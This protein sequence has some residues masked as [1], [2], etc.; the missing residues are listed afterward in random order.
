MNLQFFVSILSPLAPFFE[1][2]TVNELRINPNGTIYIEQQGITSQVTDLSLS[3][4]LLEFAVS[5]LSG[6]A[7]QPLNEQYP[8]LDVRL[9][10][11][12]RIAVLAPP[13]VPQG[14]AVTLRRFPRAYTLPELVTVGTLSQAQ[15]DALA[16][17]ILRHKNLI[18]SG[19]T[20]AGK[21][22]LMRTL[23]NLI[24]HP[25][26]RLVLIEQPAELNLAFAHVRD[27]VAMEVRDGT[28]NAPAFTATDALK[29]AL[30]HSPDRI[31]FGELRGGEAADFLDALNTGHAGSLTTLHAN[32]AEDALGRLITL[33][34]R[35]DSKASRAVI[36]DTI[37]RAIQVVVH[38]DKHADRRVV[39]EIITI[40][41][42]D[43]AGTR[44]LTAPLIPDKGGL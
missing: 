10:D 23:L 21:T 33:V 12:S 38:M 14:H 19:G 17:L 6:E 28:P 27:I 42:I 39:S 32:S 3:R 8:K 9:E 43:P 29:A 7:N 36:L 35:G 13:L 41:G 37:S 30:R 2:E 40:T 44:I 25:G 26:E 1:D 18:V 11:G 4:Q 20:G 22:T 5:A 16:H 15:A 24:P 31:I 34:Q